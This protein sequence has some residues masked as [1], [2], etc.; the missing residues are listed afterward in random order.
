[1]SSLGDRLKEARE[2]KNLKQIQVMRHTGINNKTLSGY[3]NGVSEPDMESL[4]ILADF[5][6]VDLDYLFGRQKE[7]KNSETDIERKKREIMGI[8][9]SV[10]NERDLEYTLDLIKR[11]LNK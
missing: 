5:Y 10:E 11:I 9:N 4:K 2:R 3:E 1:M 7:E 6:E 8:V